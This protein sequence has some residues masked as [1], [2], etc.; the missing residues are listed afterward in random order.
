M[1]QY[2]CFTVDMTICM[3]KKA[4]ATA[5]GGWMD[6]QTV[7][8]KNLFFPTAEPQQPTQ[9]F[10]HLKSNTRIRDSEKY[11]HINLEH[12]AM[13]PHAATLEPEC[14]CNNKRQNRKTHIFQVKVPQNQYEHFR[15]LRDACLEKLLGS[16]EN[17]AP[18]F[19]RNGSNC[20][21]TCNHIQSKSK[22]LGAFS[23]F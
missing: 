7:N 22:A 2:S 3:F 20:T 4:F 8:A 13:H 17:V 11:R 16:K 6:R 12:S 10:C 9:A 1:F 18:K 14:C 19:R 23:Q 5:R 21:V 15:W